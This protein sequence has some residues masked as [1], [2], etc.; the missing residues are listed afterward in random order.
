MA[1]VNINKSS[2]QTSDTGQT[3]VQKQGGASG[4]GSAVSRQRDWDPFA[5]SLNPAEFFNN[6]FT[7]MRRMSEEMDRTFGRFFGENA[8]GAGGR[9]GAGWLP[10]IEVAEKEGQLQVCAELPGLNPEDVKVE[11]NNDSLIIHGERKSEHEHHLGRAY[12]SERRYGQFYR[13]IQLPE[14][15]NADQIQAQY[16]NGV[17][18]IN[19]PVPRQTSNRKQI[20]INTDTGTQNASRGTASAAAAGA[21]SKAGAGSSQKNT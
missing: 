1:D 9:T 13:E 7:A 20:P 11:I 4:A 10:A 12:R 16:R 5:F 21:Q 14:G 15:V 17:L 2:Q 18:E 3:G 6:P 8:A 19:V